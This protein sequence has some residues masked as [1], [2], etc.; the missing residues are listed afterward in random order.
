[1]INAPV[2]LYG[3]NSADSLQITSIDKLMPISPCK[4]T[5][6]GVNLNL[7]RQLQSINVVQGQLY[8]KKLPDDLF[9]DRV[10]KTS[11]FYLPV[12]KLVLLYM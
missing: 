5:A 7:I 2:P 10:S 6:P 4:D 1:M 9:V 11:V 8:E 3:K 12:S